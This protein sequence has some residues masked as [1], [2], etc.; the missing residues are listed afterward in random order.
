M[1]PERFRRLE[2]LYDAAAELDPAE[3]ARFID[4]QLRGRRGLAP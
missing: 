4:E 2:A 1:N 3:R